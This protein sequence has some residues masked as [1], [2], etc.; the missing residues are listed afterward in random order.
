M[1]TRR[2]EGLMNA[3]R[4]LN[5]TPLVRNLYP[6]P[7][8]RPQQFGKDFTMRRVTGGGI[9]R[10][11]NTSWNAIQVLGINMLILIRVDTFGGNPM[12]NG[13]LLTRGSL[14]KRPQAIL[15]YYDSEGLVRLED[16]A[17]GVPRATPVPLPPLVNR[18]KSQHNWSGI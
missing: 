16:P 2:S 1:R 18:F 3:S 7:Q 14:H 4:Y 13:F 9:Q 6:W 17:A 11:S 8:N 15:Q 12:R 10:P 5:S